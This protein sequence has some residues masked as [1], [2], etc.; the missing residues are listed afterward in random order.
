MKQV[1]KE[2]DE[3]K[4]FVQWLEVMGL[5]FTAIPN[6]TYTKSWKQ[7]TH[8]RQMGLRRGFPDMV[9]VVPDKA[10]LFVEMKRKKASYA[11]EYQKEWIAALEDIAP[12]V[13]ARVCKGYDEAVAFVE[14]YIN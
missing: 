14:E 3:Q 7:K 11:N 13:D 6:S 2:E 10:L 12:N 5:K 4:A 9:V 1:P 8:N